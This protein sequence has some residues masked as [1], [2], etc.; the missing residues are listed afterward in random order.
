M[1]NQIDECFKN[2][3][4]KWRQGTGP[5]HVDIVLLWPGADTVEPGQRSKVV[6]VIEANAEVRG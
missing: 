6:V 4:F 2:A 1:I 3:G 5:V